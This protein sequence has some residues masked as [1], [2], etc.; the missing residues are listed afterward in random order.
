MNGWKDWLK[1]F[2]A[3]AAACGFI[4]RLIV[5][6]GIVYSLDD[7]LVTLNLNNGNASTKERNEGWPT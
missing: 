5:A 1:L 3:M 2:G 6:L 7:W 4:G